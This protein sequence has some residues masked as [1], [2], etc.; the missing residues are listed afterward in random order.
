VSPDVQ[1]VIGPL[2]DDLLD[3]GEPRVDI[4][5]MSDAEALEG[6]RSGRHD[7]ALCWSPG[8]PTRG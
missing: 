4:A 3:A 7:G 1:S 2:L 8:R 6:V 5:L